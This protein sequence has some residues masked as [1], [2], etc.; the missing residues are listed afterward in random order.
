MIDFQDSSQNGTY[1]SQKGA[2]NVDLKGFNTFERIDEKVKRRIMAH[3]DVIYIEKRP[4][5]CFEF[6][7]LQH[8]FNDLPN[9]L[10]VDYH[11]GHILGRGACG[12]V[13]CVLNRRTCQPFALKY[14]D[15][16]GDENRVT[17]IMK[18]VEIMRGL[19]HPCI[20]KLH[21]MQTYIDSVAILIEFMAG[22]DLITRIQNAEKKFFSERLTKFVFYQICCGVQYLHDRNVTH[23]DLKPENI[24]LATTDEYTLVKVSDFGLSKC[25][26]ANSLLQT[27]C[28]TRMYLAPE[29]RS[30]QRYTNKVDIWSLG[31]ILFNCFTGKYPFHDH[32]KNYQL[33]LRHEQ[34][35]NV[36]E[37]GKNI[38]RQ[39]LQKDA[40]L[41]PSAQQLLSQR[42]WLSKDDQIIQKACEIISNPDKQSCCV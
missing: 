7:T 10:N 6:H 20:L 16:D 36:S 12:T 17:T 5:I 28:G 18:E 29:V 27:Q 1:F 2:T 32:S 25:A 40:D 37:D 31:V 9:E 26:N 41:R 15:N 30:A 34:W 35:N 3:K 4:T 42:R 39:T 24:L 21:K 11:I 19:T 38:V 22:G 8:N 13:Y 14:T 33:K 23:R